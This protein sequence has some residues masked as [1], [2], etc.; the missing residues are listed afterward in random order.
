MVKRLL[1][2]GANTDKIT[3]SIRREDLHYFKYE[4][5]NISID[6]MQM[7][8]STPYSDGKYCLTIRMGKHYII[9][10]GDTVFYSNN[11]NGFS[12]WNT[13][14]CPVFGAC[15]EEKFFQYSLIYDFT[16][17]NYEIVEVLQNIMYHCR[18]MFIQRCHRF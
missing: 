13:E 18:D 2:I 14:S 8:S 17:L 10:R 3:Y 16:N 9:M 11:N 1:E 12:R 5:C 7:F 6:A 4:K 15:S